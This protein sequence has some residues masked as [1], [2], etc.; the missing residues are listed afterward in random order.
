MKR[1]GF[2]LIEAMLVLAIIG[3]IA[4]IAIPA[5]LQQKKR[6]KVVESSIPMATVITNN[7]PPDKIDKIGSGSQEMTFLYYKQSS[8]YYKIYTIQYGVVVKESEKKM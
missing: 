4:S 5:L 3:I 2:T 8:G 6:S 7:G 1:N